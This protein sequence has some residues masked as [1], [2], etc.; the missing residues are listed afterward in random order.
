M[1]GNTFSYLFN[2]YIPR[3]I[4]YNHENRALYYNNLNDRKSTITKYGNII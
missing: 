4:T 3:N 2:M 1:D